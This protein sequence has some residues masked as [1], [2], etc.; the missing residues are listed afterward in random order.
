MCIKYY[1][2][3]Y[4]ISDSKLADTEKLYDLARNK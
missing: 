1:I 2:S 3:K 4:Y